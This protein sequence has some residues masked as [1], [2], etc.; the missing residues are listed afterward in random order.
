ML[1]AHLPQ[2]WKAH[3]AESVE[4]G[5]KVMPGGD[6]SGPAGL[7]PMTGRGAGFC[8][9]F[10]IGGY[11]SRT[12]RL[13]FGRGFGGG[14]GFRGGR[15]GGEGWGRRHGFNAYGAPDARALRPFSENAPRHAPVDQ[16]SRKQMLKNQLETLQ[17]QVSSIQTQL[18]EIESDFPPE[19]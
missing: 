8:A 15:F 11:A 12:F 13:G 19:G 18:A 17:L 10:G 6:R 5:D 4:K 1:P 7:G 9:G 2:M 16:E 3:D 14:R